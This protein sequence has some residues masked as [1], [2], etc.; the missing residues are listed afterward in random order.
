MKQVLGVGLDWLR[1]SSWIGVAL[2]SRLILLFIIGLAWVGL[3]KLSKYCLVSY[4]SCEY[5]DSSMPLACAFHSFAISFVSSGHLL[6]CQ[7]IISTCNR[8]L[9]APLEIY[10]I[11]S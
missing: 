6:V 4:V 7:T 11:L 10:C 9:C 1:C 8:A 3:N 5:I 2:L